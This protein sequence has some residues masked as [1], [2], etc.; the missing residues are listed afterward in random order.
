MGRI[1]TYLGRKGRIAA[2]LVLNRT[3]VDWM[4]QPGTGTRYSGPA[5]VHGTPCPVCSRRLDFQIAALVGGLVTDSSG[6]IEAI[7]NRCECGTGFVVFAD[8]DDPRIPLMALGINGPN[9]NGGDK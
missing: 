3:C 2:N 5:P 9:E 7:R 1:L 4:V 8:A 6:L